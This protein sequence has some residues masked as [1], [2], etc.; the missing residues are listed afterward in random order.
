[1]GKLLSPKVSAPPAAPVE[2]KAPAV[3]ETDAAADVSVAA[4][5]KRRNGVAGT[6]TAGNVSELGSPS[7]IRQTLG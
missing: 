3:E 2:V 1:M 6:V 5:R 7:A 4:R